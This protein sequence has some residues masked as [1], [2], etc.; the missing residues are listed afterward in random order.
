LNIMRVQKGSTL[1]IATWTTSG[2]IRSRS[3]FYPRSRRFSKT[4]PCSNPFGLRVRHHGPRHM[5]PA[6]PG[7]HLPALKM[8]FLEEILS[9]LKAVLDAVPVPQ[10][11]HLLHLLV[12]KVLICDRRT[13]EVWYRLPQFTGVRTLG[14]MVAPR[15][16]CANQ[17]NPLYFGQ[18]PQAV[19]RLSASPPLKKHEKTISTL[20]F[21]N[22]LTKPDSYD[23]I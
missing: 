21:T 10:N 1:R 16:Q 9:N 8:D 6:R 3:R 12:K 7:S 2:R 19:F 14:N 23:R 20:M 22:I 4:R 11:K 18:F 5:Q 15:G 17:T 13:F